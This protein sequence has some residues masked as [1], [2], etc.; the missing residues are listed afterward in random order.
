MKFIYVIAV[1]VAAILFSA[2]IPLL[3][4][5]VMQI[6]FVLLARVQRQWLRQSSRRTFLG[7]VHIRREHSR[8]LLHARLHLDADELGKRG[9]NDPALRRAGGIVLGFLPNHVA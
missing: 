5:F 3:A 4:L 7:T 9:C 8:Q 1:F 6:P 2:I